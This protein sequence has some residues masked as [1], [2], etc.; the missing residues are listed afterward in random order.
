MLRVAVALAI[1]SLSSAAAL[2]RGEDRDVPG[3]SA[4]SVAAGIRA[5]VEIGPRRPVHIEADDEV[6]PLVETRVEG[7]ALHVGCKPDTR[8]SGEHRVTV[9]IQTPQLRTVD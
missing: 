1:A 8:L 2:A 4:V 5:S 6:L 7:G 3:F 9:T